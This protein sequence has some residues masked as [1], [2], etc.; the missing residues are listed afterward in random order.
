MDFVCC[1]YFVEMPLFLVSTIFYEFQLRAPSFLTHAF[2]KNPKARTKKCI[3][4]TFKEI[5]S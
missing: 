5:N 2:V 3:H 1:A 4:N